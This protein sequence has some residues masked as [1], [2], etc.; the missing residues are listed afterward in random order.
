MRLPHLLAKTGK[1]DM[2]HLATGW[3]KKQNY[4]KNKGLEFQG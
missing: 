1:I 4:K 3:I 2:K